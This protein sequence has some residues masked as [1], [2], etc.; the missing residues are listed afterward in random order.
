MEKV[1]RR[2]I[3]SVE[4]NILKPWVAAPLLVVDVWVY[5]ISYYSIYIYTLSIIVFIYV[6]AY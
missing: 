3:I 4:G 1:S 6:Y 5:M 2:P